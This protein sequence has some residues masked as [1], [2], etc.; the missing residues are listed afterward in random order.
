MTDYSESNQAELYQRGNNQADLIGTIESELTFNHE[1][2]GEEFY[3]FTISVPRLSGTIDHIRV[4]VS[5]RLLMETEYETGDKVKI[6]GQFRSYNSFENGENRLI[7][8]VFAKDMSLYTVDT[9]QNPNTLYLD[10][11]VCK[12]PVFRTTPFD[13]EI[14]DMLIAVNRSYN[15]SDY[16][17]T[18]AWGRNARF[19]RTFNVGDNVR[20]WGRI[21]SRQ[22]Q[23]TMPDG[24]TVTKTAFEVSVNRVELVKD[25]TPK[26]E[27]DEYSEM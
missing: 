4:V 18:I 16:I 9:G 22:Y 1:V 24:E 6:T 13:R 10:G 17:P 25:Q 23:K 21:Q 12:A 26:S 2:Y 19:A 8:T 15:K 27:S 3:T 5:E 7:L 11:Y 20:I 14:A